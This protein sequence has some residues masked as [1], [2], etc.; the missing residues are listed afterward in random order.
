M[1]AR[2]AYDFREG[3]LADDLLSFDST[4]LVLKSKY[5]T[6]LSRCPSSDFEPEDKNL[7]TETMAKQT[8]RP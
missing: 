6:R 4:A 7:N 1:T 2:D 3:T 8:C 5:Q